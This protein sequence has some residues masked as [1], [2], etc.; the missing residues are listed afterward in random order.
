MLVDLKQVCNWGTVFVDELVKIEQYGHVMHLVSKVKGSLRCDRSAI[1]L[2]R[3][4]FPGGTI[5][6]CTKVSCMEII[7]N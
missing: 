2:I 3:A 6:G 4:L 7:E 5:I 1:D